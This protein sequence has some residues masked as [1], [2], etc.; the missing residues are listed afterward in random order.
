MKHLLLCTALAL[1]GLCTSC[2]Q[3]EVATAIG[4][5]AEAAGVAAALVTTT[6]LP[7]EAPLILTGAATACNAAVD[8]LNDSTANMTLQDLM[9]LVYSTDPQVAKYKAI[10]NFCLPVVNDIIGKYMS[11]AVSDLPANVKADLIAFFGGVATGLGESSTT[12]VEKVLAKNEHARK[13]AA[14]MGLGS[15]DVNALINGL[16]NAGAKK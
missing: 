6:A 3:D 9:N 15:F 4:V 13:A 10:I 16:K 8:I 7:A 14:K 2:S 11:T 1:F 5:G 12:T